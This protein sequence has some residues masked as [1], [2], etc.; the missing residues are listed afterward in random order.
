MVSRPRGFEPRSPYFC[1][2]TQS[3]IALKRTYQSHDSGAVNCCL[4]VL[5]YNSLSLERVKRKQMDRCSPEKWSSQLISSVVIHSIFPHSFRVYFCRTSQIFVA[6][7]MLFSA[8]NNLKKISPR[9]YYQIL[10]WTFSN[11]LECSFTTSPPVSS[12]IL[13]N[14][15]APGSTETIPSNGFFTFF[16]RDR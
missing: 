8:K 11:R 10:L 16:S 4:L 12:V 9:D 15:I 14:Y 13:P 1:W 2:E 3:R 7:E 5:K 6:S